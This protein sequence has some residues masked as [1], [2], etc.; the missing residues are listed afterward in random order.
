MSNASESPPQPQARSPARPMV[1]Y[2]PRSSWIVR[3]LIASHNEVLGE[4]DNIVSSGV[5][6]PAHAREV[7]KRAK[8][9]RE[10]MTAHNLSLGET[11]P[12]IGSG[13][14][15]RAVAPYP[16]L[17]PG[18]SFDYP[19]SNRNLKSDIHKHGKQ[20]GKRFR[21]LTMPDGKT[22]RCWRVW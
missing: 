22:I 19:A 3:S 14:R 6:K 1:N 20:F 11:P 2:D 9:I 8:A 12:P 5:L 18:E 13:T 7:L 15:S 21:T 16:F 10:M 4:L 17:A